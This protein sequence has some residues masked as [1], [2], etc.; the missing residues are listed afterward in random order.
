[1]S[2]AF[3][4]KTVFQV[5]MDWA[6]QWQTYNAEQAANPSSKTTARPPTQLP[7]AV[8]ILRRFVRKE[9]IT[10]LIGFPRRPPVVPHTAKFKLS[11]HPAL[12]GSVTGDQGGNE[13]KKTARKAPQ[14]RA[15]VLRRIFTIVPPY[16]IGFLAW[17]IT[18]GDLK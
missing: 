5:R 10:T 8:S 2:H 16:T 3:E 17:A 1:M 18:S 6:K 7:G 9:G 11:N 4:L 12:G 14:V 15:S 13:I